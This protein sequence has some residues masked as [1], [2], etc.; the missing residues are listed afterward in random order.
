ME[1]RACAAAQQINTSM[2]NADMIFWMCLALRNQFETAQK[3][4]YH[5]YFQDLL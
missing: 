5:T 1:P 4:F 3:A 2:A